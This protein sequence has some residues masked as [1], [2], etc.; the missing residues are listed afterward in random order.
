MGC[1]LL[2]FFR[3]RPAGEA[4]QCASRSG[5]ERTAPCSGPQGQA[6]LSPSRCPCLASLT[7]LVP[8]GHSLVSYGFLSLC[9]SPVSASPQSLLL[10][11]PVPRYLTLP[12]SCLPLRPSLSCPP[13]SHPFTSSAPN[14]PSLSL[15]APL[16]VSPPN[17]G[18]FPFSLSPTSP[19]L[20]GLVLALAV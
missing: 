17:L 18:L 2:E 9:L 7:A 6:S 1:D 5:A 19:L 16:I 10:S 20:L 15:S 11:A 14:S 8:S 3:G 13:F 4:E 12:A